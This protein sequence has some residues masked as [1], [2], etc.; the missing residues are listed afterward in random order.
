MEYFSAKKKKKFAK[1]FSFV[2]LGTIIENI[3]YK[4]LSKK[5]ENIFQKSMIWNNLQKKMFVCD[6]IVLTKH[7]S[8]F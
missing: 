1:N 5:N 2:L 4:Q 3:F 7:T 8:R 6:M